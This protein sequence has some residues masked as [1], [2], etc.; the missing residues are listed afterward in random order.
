[1]RPARLSPLERRAQRVRR[2]PVVRRVRL[3]WTVPPVSGL[4]SKPPH[5]NCVR[6]ARRVSRANRARRV[7]LG[8]G[9]AGLAQLHQRQTVRRARRGDTR[10]QRPQ[11]APRASVASPSERQVGRCDALCATLGRFRATRVG[12]PAS[13]ALRGKP[14]TTAGPSAA[15]AGWVR[16]QQRLAARRVRSAILPWVR[17]QWERGRRHAYAVKA[18]SKRAPPRPWRLD[19]EVGDD[20]SSARLR[21]WIA[22]RKGT[23]WPTWLSKRGTGGHSTKRPQS[24]RARSP[25]RVSS[26]MRPIA[27]AASDTPVCCAPSARRTIRGSPPI[28]SASYALPRT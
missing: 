13:R 12:L 3:A 4:E 5:A 16:L 20:A 15:T 2:T 18:C 27:V 7:P 23:H 26:I 6:S 24:F 21:P 19:P 9:E 28:A 22:R 17:R 10:R 1:M 14:V 25:G 11:I 8:R